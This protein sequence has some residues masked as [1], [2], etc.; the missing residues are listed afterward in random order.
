MSPLSTRD[1][2]HQTGYAVSSRLMLALPQ[3]RP[4]PVVCQFDVEANANLQRGVTA[5]VGS[6]RACFATFTVR[7]G[8]KSDYCCWPKGCL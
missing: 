6:K 1:P 4:D 5:C 7:W 3:S 8:G 2:A